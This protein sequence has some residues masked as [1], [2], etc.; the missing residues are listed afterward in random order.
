MFK[1]ILFCVSLCF[2]AVACADK[3]H[4]VA[5]RLY[6]SAV[7]DF[8]EGN[9]N[10][11]KLRLDSI[12]NQHR[13]GIEMRRMADTLRWKIE[14]QE[15]KRNIAYYDSVIEVSQ[16]EIDN[17]RKNF[18]STGDSAIL[19]YDVFVH[20]S[21]GRHYLPH[22]NLLSEVRDNGDLYM[23][24]VFMG[25][26][27]DHT[28]YE[29][30]SEGVFKKSGEVPLSSAA[31]NRFDDLGIRWE[32]VNYKPSLQNGTAE[33]VADYADKKVMVTLKSEKSVYK[34]YLDKRDKNAIKESVEFS[35]MI[36]S[37]RNI[38]KDKRIAEDNVL[39]IQGKLN[40][41]KNE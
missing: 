37:L 26:E 32:Y 20:K 29:V 31:N 36:K 14:L 3:E 28:S 18:V 11:A 35:S 21:Q 41:D 9:Y 38:Q 19:G 15:N 40:G 13:A 10:V 22:T 30:S 2:V 1:K 16:P 39:W 27:L 5:K 17:M 8:A 6:D 24:S 4:Q 12:H 23:I 7:A 34:F 25:R 33:F